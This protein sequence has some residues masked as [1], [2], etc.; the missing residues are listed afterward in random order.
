MSL[1]KKIKSCNFTNNKH[2][3]IVEFSSIPT[4]TRALLTRG[5]FVLRR[6]KARGDEV[7]P[8]IFRL[9]W[10]YYSNLVRS[11]FLLYNRPVAGGQTTAAP[12]LGQLDRL[13]EHMPFSN[14]LMFEIALFSSYEPVMLESMYVKPENFQGGKIR[15]VDIRRVWIL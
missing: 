1:Y 10:V 13:L 11:A 9:L 8:L 14:C 4:V 15:I 12:D 7:A 2:P 5:R 6:K 3:Q